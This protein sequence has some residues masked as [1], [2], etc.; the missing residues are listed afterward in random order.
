[1]RVYVFDKQVPHDLCSVEK[2]KTSS[3]TVWRLIVTSTWLDLHVT[4]YRSKNERSTTP[5]RAP[6]WPY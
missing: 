1:M 4:G 5:Y 2:D 3:L 6:P